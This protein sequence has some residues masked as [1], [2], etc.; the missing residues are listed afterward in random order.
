M[1]TFEC[2]SARR[3][4]RGY[5]ATPVEPEKIGK[6]VQ[7]ALYAPVGMHD[8]G[9]LRLTVVQNK[10][11]LEDFVKL[12][13]QEIPQMP[14]SPIHGAPVL[15]VVS[16]SNTSPVGYANTACLIENMMLEATELGLGSLYVCGAFSLLKDNAELIKLFSI[17]EGYS[18]VSG[19]AIGYCGEDLSPRSVKNNETA[20]NYLL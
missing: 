13:L 20:V 19:V 14:G 12:A 5:E 18:P 10:D 11:V 3:S 17:P 7:A 6:I 1:N 16:T 8:Y 4:V 15:I 2:I 9:S